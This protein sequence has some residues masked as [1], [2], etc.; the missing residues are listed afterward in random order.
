MNDY[1]VS[2]AHR[3]VGRHAVKIPSPRDTRHQGSSDTPINLNA[4]LEVYLDG[5]VLYYAEQASG[6]R[7]RGKDDY[8]T[9]FNS[10]RVPEHLPVGRELATRIAITGNVDGYPE[11]HGTGRLS[12]TKMS[13]E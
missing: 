7:F 4:V 10:Y 11:K 12:I 3:Y 6:S 5:R 8:G 2:F 13:D 9:F 1:I